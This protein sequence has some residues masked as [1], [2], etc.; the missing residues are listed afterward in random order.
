MTLT[1]ACVCGQAVNNAQI[2][3]QIVDPS[4]G[5]VG[6]AQIKATQLETGVVRDTSSDASGIYNLPD[7]SV[8]PYQLEVIATGFQH[9]V[10]KGIILQVGQDVQIN[11]ALQ[12]GKMTEE[13][14]VSADAVMAETRETS[15]SAVLDQRRIVDLPLDG[16]Q[17]TQLVTLSGAATTPTII[18]NNDLVSTKNYGNGQGVSSVAISVA[19]GQVNGTNYLLD[20]GDNNDMFS[21]VNLPFPFPDAIQEFS[22]QTSTASARYGVHPGATVNIVTKAGTNS[23]H[24]DVFEFIRNNAVNATPYFDFAGGADT[25]KRNQYGGTLGGPILRDKLMFFAGYQGTQYHQAAS[26]ATAQVPTAAALTGNFSG[27]AGANCA[28]EKLKAPYF[29]TTTDVLNSGYTF[30]QQALNLLALVPAPDSPTD[31]CGTVHYAIP[32]NYVE[33]QGLGRVDW[34]INSRQSLFGRY[35]VSDYS[36]PP[37]YDGKDI[38]TATK[39]GELAR[40]QSLTLG[41]TYSISSALVNSLHVTGTRLA[42][43][44]GSASNLPNFDTFGV[45]IPNP[46]ANSLVASITGYFNVANGT[47][48]PGHFNRNVL[49]AADDMD[50]TVGKHQL[51]FGADLIHSRLNELSNQLTNG[52]FAFSGDITGDGLADFLLGLPKTFNQGNPEW[53]NWRQTYWGLYAQDSFKVTPKLTLNAGVRWE[54]F[55]PAQD[56]YHRGS[57][58][59]DALY[60]Q[61]TRSYVFPSAPPG[62]FYCYD[63]YTPCSYIK[64]HKADFSPRVGVAWDPRG[65]GRETIRAGYAIFYDNPE[66][67]Y[68][69]RF[70]DNSPFGSSIS[71]NAPAGGFTNPYQGQ[72]VPKFPTP[73]P[74]TAD[75][76]FFANGVYINI[77]QNLK[78]TYT[79]SWDLSIEKQLRANWLFTVTY[80]GNKTTHIW[81]GYAADAP[82]LLG[83]AVLTTDPRCTKTTLLA[84]CVTN[85]AARQ[86]LT[87]QN[88]MF[89]PAGQ[90]KAVNAGTYFSTISQASD[91]YNAEYN[92]VMFSANH[93]FSGNFTVLANYTYSHCIS[94]YD[95]EGE[96]ASGGR[97]VAGTN[98]TGTGPDSLAEERANCSFD[99][100][101]VVNTSFVATSP[102]FSGAVARKLLSNWELSGL[103][104]YQTGSYFTIFSAVDN[105]LTKV[106]ND[107]ADIVPGVSPTSGTCTVPVTLQVENVHSGTCWF[108]KTAFTTNALG[109]IGDSGRNSMLGPSYFTI[110]TALVRSFP[111]RESLQ[112][113]LRFEVFNLLNHPIFNNPGAAGQ[114][115]L[116]ANGNQV[117]KTNEGLITSTPQDTQRILQAAVKITF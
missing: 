41:H 27:L 61:G 20:G 97:L 64:G 70:A 77:P 95:F 79:Q 115:T 30:N 40:S 74:T 34:T 71:L 57:Y 12:V 23:F 1:A 8:G 86:L 33:N 24:G 116:T 18:P 76:T 94:E 49:Q 3:G 35:F 51:T 104:E 113:D 98:A 67:F 17:A 55:S 105:S 31:P 36:N 19:G 109:T 15:V 48:T 107:R 32:N 72:T 99:R 114:S 102:R 111:I 21:D 56:A 91:I 87:L 101:Q 2:H 39:A 59:S 9:Y 38:L 60:A 108:N 63:P 45:N 11:V 5:T 28:N 10:Q 90:T 68:F 42:L 117:A 83:P 80:L 25:L 43:F 89:T 96:L 54:P 47:A 66:V 62:L 16:R 73:F 84:S 75:N 4:G 78:P 29:N 69:D 26:T 44:R 50:W 53:E 92:G 37:V 103:G 85:E 88:V 58:F 100:R 110:N 106:G 81:G 65:N 93:R 13:I 22:V 52:Q 7:L 112:L 46:I 6:G 14:T 82:V